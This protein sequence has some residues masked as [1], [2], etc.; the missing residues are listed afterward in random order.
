MY[1]GTLTIQITSGETSE[2][3]MTIGLHQGSALSPYL[4]VLVMHNLTRHLQD[5]VPRCTLFG[6]DIVL[7]DEAQNSVNKKLELWR[8]ALESKGFKI[9]WT[10]T[11]H[12][13]CKLV[14]IGVEMKK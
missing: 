5:E 7:I 11:K 4:F 2:F 12:M 13:K 6:D 14:I 3:S 9:S 1:D 10:K 8:D